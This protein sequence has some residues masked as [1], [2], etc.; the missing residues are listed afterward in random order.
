[1]AQLGSRWVGNDM[2]ADDSAPSAEHDLQRRSDAGRLRRIR[3]ASRSRRPAAHGLGQLTRVYGSRPVSVA[4]GAAEVVRQQTPGRGGQPAGHAR[5]RPRGVPDRLHRLRRD[6]LPR[7]H[8][9]GSDLRPG[10]RRADGRS[11][12]PRHGRTRCA[13]RAFTRLDVV[14]DYRWGRV[15]ETHGRGPVPGRPAGR[16]LRPRP[17]GCRDHRHPQALRRLLGLSRGS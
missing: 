3:H 14:R 12:R 7:G 8:R 10:A 9:L 15:E 13:S 17:A 1:M 5:A 11:D 2:H 16:R 6:R 4:A